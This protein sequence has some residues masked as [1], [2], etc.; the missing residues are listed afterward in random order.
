[1]KSN[2]VS[3]C[4]IVATAP[5]SRLVNDEHVVTD[6]RLA[7]RQRIY[8]RGRNDWVDGRT[9]WVTISCWDALARNVSTCLTVGNRVM[10]QGRLISSEWTTEAGRRSRVE[11]RADAIG[12]D[13]GFGTST[14]ERVSW[15]QPREVQG[16]DE[17][18]ELAEQ[19]ER[20]GLDVDLDQLLARQGAAPATDDDRDDPDDEELARLEQLQ[21]V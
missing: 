15:S 7:W 13:L 14:F 8:D 4:G 16:P 3:I 17:A 10:V 20:E 9:T 19:V 1:M 12:F 18:D 6:F 5:K 11:V 2:T 21:E